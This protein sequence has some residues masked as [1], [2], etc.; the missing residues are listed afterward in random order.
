MVRII[1]TG[2]QR[3][4]LHFEIIII[5]F[6]QCIYNY[7]PETN[8]VPTLYN[9]AA[10]LLLQYMADFESIFI[11]IIIIIIIT[12]TQCIYNYVPETNY[13]ATVYNV[14]AILLLQY[15][16]CNAISHYKP[17]VLY[18]STSCSLCSAHC[19]CSV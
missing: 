18:N 19:G 10:I 1:A 5:T 16:T 3:V 2:L 17:F 14:A 13:V 8:H 15:M 12:F 7:V 11:I 6:T 9:V 4:G